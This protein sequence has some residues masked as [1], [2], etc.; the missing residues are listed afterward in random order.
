MLGGELVGVGKDV[1]GQPLLPQRGLELHHG[2]HG[3]EDVG[4]AV[5]ELGQVA[6]EAGDFAD[7]LVELLGGHAARLVINEQGGLVD[8]EGNL[9]KGHR[10][11]R[12]NPLRGDAVV[13]IDQDFAQVKDNCFRQNYVIH[14]CCI[15][16]SSRRPSRARLKVSSSANSRPVPAGSPWAMRVIRSPSCASRLAR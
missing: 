2:F 15:Y 11:A 3:G 9:A 14:E 6:L 7:L 12:G 4:E 16:N 5:P 13:E 1:S 8:I 10:A